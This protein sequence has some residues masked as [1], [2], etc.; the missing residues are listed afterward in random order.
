MKNHLTLIAFTASLLCSVSSLA[1]DSGLVNNDKIESIND[2]FSGYYIY[3]REM[4]GAAVLNGPDGEIGEISGTFESNMVDSYNG[5]G[6][7]IF[8]FGYIGA[9]KDTIFEENGVHGTRET[10][11]GAISNGRYELPVLASETGEE[12]T[13]QNSGI[14]K[15]E[16]VTFKRNYVSVSPAPASLTPYSTTEGLG[17]AIYNESSIGAISNSQFIE[18]GVMADSA[19]G[20]AI[21]NNGE[22]GNITSDFIGNRVNGNYEGLGGA[23]ANNGLIKDISGEFR[24][25]LISGYFAAGGSI[26]NSGDIGTVTADFVGNTVIGYEEALGGAIANQGGELKLVNSNFYDN[27]VLTLSGSSA[28]GGAVAAERIKVVADGKNSEFKGNT[29]NGVSNALFVFSQQGKVSALNDEYR[30]GSYLDVEANNSGKVIFDDGIDGTDYDVYVSGDGSGEVVFNNVV[31]N[32]STFNAQSGSVFHLGK[33]AEINTYDYKADN[34]LLKVDMA[35]DAE[36]KKVQSGII[37]VSGDVEGKTQVIVNAENPETFEGAAVKFVDAPNDVADTAASFDVARVVGSP[38]MWRSKT[39]LGGEEQGN[40]WY[41]ALT[42]ETNPDYEKPSYAPEVANYAGIQ[43][44][45]VEQNRSITDSVARGIAPEKSIDCYEESCGVAEQAL[46]KKA[47]IDVTV[48]NAELKSPVDMDADIKG[49]TA[50]VDLY[51]EGAHR[52]GV[53]GA[54]RNGKYDVSGKGDYYSYI[55]SDI[56]TDSYLGGAYYQYK[57]DDWRMLGTAF[58][59]KQHMDIST[60]DHIAF[61]STDALQFG[62]S[63]E[64][65]KRIALDDYLSLEPSLGVRYTMLDIDTLHDN[66]GKT[67]V[68]DTVHYLEAELGLKVERVFCHNSCTNRAYVKP[69]IIQTVVNGGKTKISG[70]ENKVKSLKNQTLGRVEVGG[71]FGLTDSWTGFASTGYTLGDDYQAYDLNLG[72]SYKF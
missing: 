58:I 44:A 72:V 71:E 19:L 46:H 38:Y 47:W 37:N 15:I 4:G 51:A 13:V 35:V 11:G 36:N 50:G 5:G 55:G 29:A 63:A 14:G 70:L 52:A 22:M 33:N 68:F 60:D 59:G 39:N 61:A 53:F 1:T 67:A 17:G 69:S 57:R 30:Y 65:A 54:Y 32:V 7:A 28:Q 25:N 6:G 64:A 24:K 43:S 31:D 10:A 41:L 9:V 49:T 26:Y 20:G 45:A 18:N 42:D 34:A 40:S 2:T 8:N 48:E 27:S 66:V 21:F 3:D 56:K 62:M 16:N 23:I 12:R